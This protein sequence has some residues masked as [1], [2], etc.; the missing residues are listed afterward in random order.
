MAQDF[1]IKTSVT[2]EI[3]DDLLLMARQYGFKTRAE[4]VRWLILR[5]LTWS[6]SQ[7]QITQMPGMV[8][9]RK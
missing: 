9:G 7:L 6:K 3:H 8:K 4:C 1:D 2:E 5:E